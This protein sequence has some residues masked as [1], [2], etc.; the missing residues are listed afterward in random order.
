MLA[1]LT[2]N[3]RWIVRD[4]ILQAL[5]AVAVFLV[6]LVPVISSFS[7]RQTQEMAI[8]LALSFNSFILLVYALFLGS[9][10]VWRD[11][12]RRYSY[13]VLSL[14]VDR[15]SYLLAKFSSLALFLLAST[16]L[17]DLCSLLVIKLVI[18][19][20]PSTTPVS[21]GRI[22]LAMTMDLLKSLLVASLAM[23]VTTVA[24]SFF[25]P[26][27]TTLMLYLAGSASQDVYEYVT[28]SAGDRLPHFLRVVARV[29]YFIIPNF[30]VFDFKLQAIYP[31][32]LD[33]V[34]LLYA[35]VYFFAY[36]LVVQTTAIILLSRREIT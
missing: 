22:T 19:Q 12:E 30:S 3:L 1:M 23:L 6:F 17:I 31:I 9:T 11:L 21:F 34:H 35:V 27:F 10:L 36:S 20:S 8:T 5:I 33:L 16:A 26:F 29:L 28:S 7:M 15:A 24:T 13:A 2:V 25:M 32:S 4:R 14:P 18:L